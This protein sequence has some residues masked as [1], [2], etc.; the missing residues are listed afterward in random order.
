MKHRQ[1]PGPSYPARSFFLCIIPE[2][3]KKYPLLHNQARYGQA[4]YQFLFCNNLSDGVE[5]P[6]LKIA[7]PT[8]FLLRLHHGKPPQLAAP[9]SAACCRGGGAGE[10]IGFLFLLPMVYW[11]HTNK[12][13]VGF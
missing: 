4:E 8:L 1:C 12:P 3:S 6:N 10:L 9:G 7:L 5:Y 11:N 13:N 2:S